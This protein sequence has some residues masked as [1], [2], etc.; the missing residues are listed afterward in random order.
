VDVAEVHLKWLKN[1]QSVTAVRS[2]AEEL[3]ADDISADEHEE[4]QHA[5]GRGRR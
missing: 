2:V 4:E 1:Q 5:E 3:A